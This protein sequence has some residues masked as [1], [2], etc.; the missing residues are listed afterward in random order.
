MRDPVK[1]CCL[2]GLA[3]LVS[4]ALVLDPELDLS[5][6]YGDLAYVMLCHGNTLVLWRWS[7]INPGV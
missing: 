5:G 1:L 4:K 3:T 2:E 6:G 7:V